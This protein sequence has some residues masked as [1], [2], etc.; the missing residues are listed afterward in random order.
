MNLLH[1]AAHIA[2]RDCM[3]VQPHERVLVVTDSQRR[4][5][6]QALFAAATE[7]AAEAFVL[8]MQPRT[9]DGEEPPP[10][11]AEAM[12][13]AEVV[14]CPTTAS[15]T[16]TEARRNACK[17][18]ARVG[19]M[20]GITEEVMTR[21]LR[22]DYHQIAQRTRKLAAILTNGK[23][24]RVT[25]PA[26]TDITIPI[27]GIQAIASTGLVQEP[28]SFGNL[29]SGEAYLMPREGEAE[30]V[31]VVDG[32]LAGIGLITDEPVRI[33][34]ERGMAVSIEGGA[35]ARAFLRTIEQVGEDARNLAE[36]GVGTNDMARINGTIL[37]DEKV[38]GTV[39]LAL[40]NNVSMGGTVNVPFH[41]DGVLRNPTLT[42]D[43]QTV[44]EEG[45]LRL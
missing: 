26:G 31:I 21:T 43:G 19:T 25:T 6:G 1:E 13:R 10:L 14:I 16:H 33:V 45:N 29:P 18:G 39:H 7:L 22:A 2:L 30:G 20:P 9:V 38:L 5:I 28:G 32:S 23:T 44:L 12:T 37:E 24:A 17:A 3:G 11:V 15:L 27:E 40:G 34:V 4:S 35:Q 8:E 42:I 41:V 36:L